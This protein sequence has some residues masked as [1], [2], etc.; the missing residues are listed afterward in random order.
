MTELGSGAGRGPW[1]SRVGIGQG[2]LLRESSLR[3]STCAGRSV[4]VAGGCLADLPHRL[5]PLTG[6]MQGTGQGMPTASSTCFPRALRCCSNRAVCGLG[7]ASLPWRIHSRCHRLTGMALAL[8]SGMRP[9][10]LS[11]EVSKAAASGCVALAHVCARTRD[12]GPVGHPWPRLYGKCDVNSSRAG[13]NRD[14][15]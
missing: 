14:P 9:K 1:L 8:T 10:S 15:K 2:L 13:F 12:K 5:L 4:S 11:T 3:A 7:N 6:G